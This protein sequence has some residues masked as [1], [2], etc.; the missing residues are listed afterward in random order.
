MTHYSRVTKIVIDAPPDTHD[1]EVVFWREALGLPLQ[2]FERFPDFHGADLTADG[3]IGVLVQRLGDGSAKVHLDI[4]TNDRTAEVAR[5]EK[6]GA[7]LVDDGEHWTIMR[8]PAGLFLR[9]A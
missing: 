6:L 5:L 2:H 4:H 8:D 1:R 3:R 7:T 9:R